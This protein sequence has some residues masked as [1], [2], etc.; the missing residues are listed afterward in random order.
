MKA[1]SLMLVGALALPIAADAA[2]PTLFSS[3]QV[4]Q[5]LSVDSISTS[6]RLNVRAFGATGDGVTDDTA[7][8]IA[9]I[10][11]VNARL[12]A[13]SPATL[14]VP[15]GVYYINGASLPTFTRGGSLA[16]DGPHKTYI[17][18]GPAYSGDLFSWSDAWMLNSYLGTSL[19]VAS[20]YAGPLIQGLSVLGSRT[21]TNQQNA[22]VFYDRDDMIDMR[23]VHVF[24]VNGRGMFMGVV[25]NVPSQAY[26]RESRFSNLLFWQCGTATLP[27]VEINSVGAAGNDATNELSFYALDIIKPAGKGLVIRNGN[28]AAGVR[29]LRFFGLRV[30][31]G[32]AGAAGDLLDIGDAAFPGNVNNVQIYGFESNNSA[33]TAAAIR[34]SAASSAVMP[35]NVLIEGTIPTSNGDAVH[36]DAGRQVRLHLADVHVSSGTGI[37]VGPSTLVGNNIEIDG[38]GAEM[39]WSYAIDPSALSFVRTPASP[40]LGDPSTASSRAVT[41]GSRPDGTVTGGIGRGARAV[42][43]QS[44]RTA[45]SQVASGVAAAV[46]AGT[47]N[48][49]SASSAATIGGT[50]NASN[51]AYSFIGGGQ[52]NTVSGSTAAALAGQGNSVTGAFGASLAGLYASDRGRYG[53]LAFGSGNFGGST[54]GDAELS[55]GVLRAAVASGGTGQLTADG[56]AAGTA[57]ILNLSAGMAGT[58]HGYASVRDVTTGAMYSFFLEFGAKRPGVASTTAVTWQNITA[59]GG[60]STLAQVTLTVQA[61]TTNGGIKLVANNTASPSGNTLH[62]AFTPL[63]TEVQ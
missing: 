27:S 50:G 10:Q 51:G 61:D 55:A 59:K 53:S 42:D 47:N 62:L 44:S 39:S 56:A 38:D 63:G 57:N 12:A 21:Y 7:A 13:G 18:M 19:S 2:Y 28:P 23:D 15:A 4:P 29:L 36:I 31:G 34:L 30:E 35:Y 43:M 17:Q 52:S 49:A 46:I 41:L 58:Y 37:T 40:L 60:D 25:K 3:G 24:F 16:G 9:A 1:A 5:R 8:F 6:S 33:A 11:Q 20:D 32:A 48:T 14:Y 26:V 45:A 54:T 22:F